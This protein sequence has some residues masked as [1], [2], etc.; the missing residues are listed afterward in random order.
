MHLLWW[1]E[2]PASLY[3]FQPASFIKLSGRN[4]AEPHG[5]SCHLYQLEDFALTRSATTMRPSMNST[6][7]LRFNYFYLVLSMASPR[8][9]SQELESYYCL[10]ISG[11]KIYNFY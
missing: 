3:T 11:L 6:N 9:Q 1:K 5:N 10:P 4:F 8:T 7:S 2:A